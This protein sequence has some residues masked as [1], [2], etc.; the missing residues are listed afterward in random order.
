MGSGCN[1][2]GKGNR[3]KAG[4]KNESPVFLREQENSKQKGVSRS[5]NFLKTTSLLNGF[6]M[7]SANNHNEED[8][9]YSK[10]KELIGPSS[11]NNKGELQLD[12]T[13]IIPLEHEAIS[14]KKRK[15]FVSYKI[16]GTVVVIDKTKKKKEFSQFLKEH[17]KLT[18]ICSFQNN[19]EKEDDKSGEMIE[20]EKFNNSL[21]AN[22]IP[23]QYEK[24]ENNN[25]PSGFSRI[26]TTIEV[27]TGA[28]EEGD[29]IKNLK[30]N[31]N[32]SG[33]E[34]QTSKNSLLVYRQSSFKWKAKML[35]I[36]YFRFF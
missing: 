36:D 20:K 3:E 11:K 10:K 5:Q 15:L 25:V 7:K 32:Q 24:R 18:R 26:K 17:Q 6:S 16:A 8:K 27:N 12:P 4:E 23:L 29:K 30:D 9:I 2:C 35:K 31:A 21:A 22:C 33:Q 28:N 13:K 34:M 19:N 14:L 1:P